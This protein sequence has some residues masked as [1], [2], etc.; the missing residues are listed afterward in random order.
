[1]ENLF[2]FVHRFIAVNNSIDDFHGA[3]VY[4]WIHGSIQRISMFILTHFNVL[5]NAIDNQLASNTYITGHKTGRKITILSTSFIGNYLIRVGR[6]EASKMCMVSIFIALRSTNVQTWIMRCWCINAHQRLM[7]RHIWAN[8]PFACGCW[9]IRWKM[10]AMGKGH[11]PWN[12]K[13]NEVR[14]F[15]VRFHKNFHWKCVCVLSI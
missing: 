1:M 12:L 10:K 15:Y 13:R 3:D 2:Q 8:V 9:F 7:R 4:F 14:H 6:K 5:F 11:V